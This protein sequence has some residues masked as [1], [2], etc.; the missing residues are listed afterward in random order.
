MIHVADGM[1]TDAEVKLRVEQL[2]KEFET[3]HPAKAAA[4]KFVSGLT[5]AALIP[6]G[7]ISTRQDREAARVGDELRVRFDNLCDLFE[8]AD[9]AL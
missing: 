8:T 1:M 3:N 9:P 4:N 5:D 7:A 6:C 2:Y